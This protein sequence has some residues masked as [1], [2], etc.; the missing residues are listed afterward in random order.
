MSNV[1]RTEGGAEGQTEG[2]LRTEDVVG[3][4]GAE[5]RA[6]CTL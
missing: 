2:D 6:L 4:P 3:V 5:R 1:I